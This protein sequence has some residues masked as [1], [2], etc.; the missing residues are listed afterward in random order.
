MENCIEVRINASVTKEALY[1]AYFVYCHM[2]TKPP[3]S[4]NKF[5]RYLKNYPYVGESRPLV[6]DKQVE[7]WIG[8]T[9]R[10]ESV[11]LLK[12]EKDKMDEE[13]R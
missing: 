4:K 1:N 6:G 11:E 9:L 10:K 8:I 5:G 7:A 13:T 3:V 12:A 2:T